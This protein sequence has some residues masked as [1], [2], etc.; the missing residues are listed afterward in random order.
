[1]AEVESGAQAFRLLELILLE[2]LENSNKEIKFTRIWIL[3]KRV[4][5]IP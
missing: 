3:L 4:G 5:Q 2:A 1:M